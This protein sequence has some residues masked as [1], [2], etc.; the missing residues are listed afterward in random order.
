MNLISTDLPAAGI[1]ANETTVPLL[2]CISS[3]ETTAFYRALGFEIAYE[4][5]KPYLYLAFA[6]SGFQLHYGKAPQG[7]DPAD[8]DAGGC[9]VMV[10]DVASYHAAF[11]AAM[12]ASYGKVLAKGRP[13]IT[14][15][16]PGATR[17]TLVDP[18]GNSIIF[19]RR[20]EPEDLEYGGDKSLPPLRR[21]LDNARIYREF[22]NDDKAAFRAVTSALR[23]HSGDAT[24]VN[25]AIAYATLIELATALDE[26]ERIPALRADLEALLTELDDDERRLVADD[27]QL[28]D[29]LETW[30]AESAGPRGR[31]KPL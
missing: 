20:D 11:T 19:I 24:P 17:F 13:R 23:R 2:P 10:D 21:A 14:R 16:R 18:T 1:R 4:M 28:A 5:H 6:M 12:R 9:L 31:A 8:E 27:L 22:K 26:R 3:E 7:I 15:Y 30:I 25:R 29:D